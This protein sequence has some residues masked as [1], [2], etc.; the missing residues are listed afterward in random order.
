MIKPLTPPF[1]LCKRHSIAINQCCIRR[2]LKI[3]CCFLHLMRLCIYNT[4]C[5]VY[6]CFY[7]YTM[8]CLDKF[9]IFLLFHFLATLY[10]F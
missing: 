5:V 2:H 9:Y 4:V 7:V 3:Y 10:F 1:V 8:S 6:M